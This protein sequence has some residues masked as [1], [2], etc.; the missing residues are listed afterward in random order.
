M[1]FDIVVVLPGN[2]MIRCLSHAST[3]H[4]F[5]TLNNALETY[6]R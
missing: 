2:L 3:L 4:M 5:A 1:S 6:K